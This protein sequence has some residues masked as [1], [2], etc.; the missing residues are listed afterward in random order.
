MYQDELRE[1]LFSSCGKMAQNARRFCCCD[2]NS[3]N[4]SI[5]NT[6]KTNNCEWYHGAWQ[7]LRAIDCVSSP[8]W[9]STWYKSVFEKAF[10]SKKKIDILISGTAD[11]T[12]LYFLIKF[13]EN[14]RATNVRIDI[15]DLCETPL[16]ICKW[17]A[18]NFTSINSNIKT[19]TTQNS[20]LMQF[21]KCVIEIKTIR[22]NILMYSSEYRYDV[23]C[24]D[25]FL[26]RFSAKEVQ[27]IVAKWK[28]CLSDDG[29]IIT[30]CR[31]RK[32]SEAI[33]KNN[34]A[35]MSLDINTFCNKVL[36]NYNKLTQ[37]EKEKIGISS[38]ELRYIALRYVE[39]FKSNPL[40]LKEDLDEVFA[41]LGLKITNDS[42]TKDVV[43]EIYQTTYYRICAKKC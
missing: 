41:S 2:F 19:E 7:Y 34:L 33:A 9:H 11:Y 38:E 6:I 29:S 17:L 35:K 16:K 43:G 26:T 18:T 1:L 42:E 8:Q 10:G 21:S 39:R 30:T 13:I 25:A 36:D 24:S 28:N 40:G 20:I 3:H 31:L 12:F 22:C 15:V 23:I 4:S 5:H 14:S 27:S 37:S 32:N